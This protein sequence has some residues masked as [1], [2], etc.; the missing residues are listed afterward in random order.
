MFYTAKIQTSLVITNNI[1]TFILILTSIITYIQTLLVMARL[2][3]F[4]KDLPAA[5]RKVY[6]LIQERT[7]GNVKAF[8]ELIGVS[9]QVLDRTFRI[10]S[11]SGKFPSVS[12]K[13]KE[14]LWREFGYDE[15]WLYSNDDSGK[16]V[17]QED[18]YSTYLLPMSAMGGSLTGFAP[19]G[20]ALQ[21]CEKI[22]SPIKGVDFAISVYG[23]S[24][25]PEYPSGSKILIKK[26]NPGIFIDWGKAYVL[27]TPNGVIVKEIH[28]CK[29]K[30]GYIRCHSINPDPKFSDFDVPLSEVYGMYRVLMCLSAK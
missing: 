28:E 25:A 27:D 10:D 5:N 29:E 3:D 8:A 18:L 4:Y 20:T 11:R 9:Q 30:E 14:G 22:I 17:Y 7:D 6:N 21:E 13:I 12:E 26:I 23:E 24:M 15:S 19:Q 1:Q 16:E 2:S